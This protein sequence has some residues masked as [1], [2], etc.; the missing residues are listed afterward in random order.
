VSAIEKGEAEYLAAMRAGH[1]T[2]IL[3]LG[4]AGKQDQ[5]READWQVE[6]LQ[7]T[8]A[9]N[10]ANL[11]YYTGLINGEIQYQSLV[12]SA[13]S[14]RA[15][16]N[17]VEAIGEGLRLIPD[18]V[19]GAA[20]FG[21]SPVAISWLPLGTKLGEMFSAVSRIINNVAQIESE[22]AGLGLTEAG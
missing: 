6:S 21:G 4:L 3:A 19:V 10:Q 14:L 16:A 11:A 5:W 9:V 2:E 1:E 15:E 20:G 17:A 18:S 12:N 8:K 7:K 22:N 13:L